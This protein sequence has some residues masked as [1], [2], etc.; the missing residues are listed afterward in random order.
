MNTMKHAFA[1]LTLGITSFVAAP[2][3]AND[4][5]ANKTIV[6]V[7]LHGSAA[8]QVAAAHFNKIATE[9]G[10]RYVAVSRGIEVNSSVPV[11]IR[12]GLSLDGLAPVNDVPKP[13]TPNEAAT[14][15]RLIAFDPVPDDKR[16]ES[17]VKYWS[18][19]PPVMR[20]Y[21]AARDAITRHI[22]DLAPALE[23][24]AH[25]QEKLLGMIAGVDEEKDQVTLKVDSGIDSSFK[26][27]DG[28]IFNAIHRGDYV[29]VTVETIGGK[30]T[31]VGLKK[32]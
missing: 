24:Q 10:L 20:D 4:T 17:E 8:S 3:H 28:L 5:T 15:A 7:C 11:H 25:P 23:Q 32:L 6:F 9:R 30:K 22:D 16:G 27:Q 12:D 26:V 21:A 13:L 14:A 31:I 29:E 1:L 2:A 19:V 18:D